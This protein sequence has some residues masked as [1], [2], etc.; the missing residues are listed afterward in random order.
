MGVPDRVIVSEDLAPEGGVARAGQ[1]IGHREVLPVGPVLHI[2]AL[3]P[4]ARGRVSG[5][6]VGAEDGLEPVR[7]PE[8]DRFRLPARIDDEL[9]A[10][11][12]EAPERGLHRLDEC[13]LGESLRERPVEAAAERLEHIELDRL[14]GGEGFGV[15]LAPGVPPVPGDGVALRLEVGNRPPGRERLEKL[16]V[17]A[18]TSGIGRNEDQYV[19]VLGES[20]LGIAA[21]FSPNPTVNRNY[22][23]LIP[24]QGPDS[25]YEIVERIPVLGE[26]DEL[27]TEAVGVKHLRVVLKEFGQL[28]LLSICS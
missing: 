1:P 17:D 3:L 27:A 15:R 23:F 28:V 13:S 2:V 5:V 24:A 18:F 14:G 25:L 16:E 20:L 21:L 6:H 11:P 10:P 4:L 7:V 12:A 22:S 8:L 19:L 9:P 26:D